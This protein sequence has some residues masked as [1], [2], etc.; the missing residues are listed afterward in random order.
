LRVTGQLDIPFPA[1]NLILSPDGQCLVVADAFGGRLGLVDV[2]T[3]RYKA[4]RSFPAHNIR[5]L[6]S[7][8][9]GSMLVVAHQMLNDLAHTT[10][11]DVHWGLLMSNDLRWLRWDAVLSENQDIYAGSHMHPLGEAGSA[12]ADPSGLAM[13]PNG[14]VVVTLGG[15]GEVAVGRE[16]DFTLFRL[17]VGRRPTA[18]LVQPD[19]Q[20]AIIA[21][22]FDDSLTVLDL[23]SRQVVCQIE[24]GPM[25]PL[26]LVDQ[27]E[28]LFYDGRL[29]HDGWMSCHSCHTDGHT[30][31]GLNDNFSDLTFGAP[32]RV[33][34][35]LGVARTAP[36]GWLGRL[37]DLPTQI[38]NSIRNTMQGERELSDD[39]IQ[40]LV[41]F[42]SNLE[43]PP[44][45][46]ELRGSRDLAAIERGRRVFEQRQ[47]AR[48]HEPPDY[49]SAKSYDVGLVD[50]RG[51]RQFNPP[52]LRGLS[53]RGPYLHDNAA[54]QLED[55][56]RVFGHPN[57]AQ[58]EDDELQDLVAF[59]RSL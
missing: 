21:N 4:T 27:G 12:T 24:L 55:V 8:V 31:G 10:R 29:S 17:R 37:D 51:N 58:Y 38:K 35:L 48:C 46:D 59:L 54:S 56:F 30:N 1:R 53:H 41:A 18:V 36:Y 15:V 6:A 49:T 45:L 44:S 39:E 3:F 16:S 2:N 47:C 50:Q 13:A 5:G 9:D 57:D 23:A 7:S 43:V 25:A 33:L 14:M 40:S 52:S 22:T 26:T 42:L 11:N 28:L 20:R 32:K 19:G 34:S